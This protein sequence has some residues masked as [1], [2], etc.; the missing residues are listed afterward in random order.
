MVAVFV[1]PAVFDEVETVFHP[2]MVAH[3]HQ[4]LDRSDPRWIEAGNEVSHVVRHE[5]AVGFAN[6]TIDPQR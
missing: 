3:Q 2:P 1:P 4:E 6:F 5:L